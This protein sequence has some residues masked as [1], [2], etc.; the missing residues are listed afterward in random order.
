MLVSAPY[1]KVTNGDYRAVPF[2]LKRF[3]FSYVPAPRTFVHLREVKEASHAPRPF[4]GFGDFRG[5]S[6][7]QL[8]AAFP[9]PECEPD[10]S[11]LSEL[12]ALAG[13]RQEITATGQ[14]LGAGAEDIFLAENFTR[15]ALD[16]IDFRLY[17]VVHFATHA[18]L[19]TE[20]RC[21][22]EPTILLSVAANAASA[23]DAFLDSG[24]VLKLQMDADLVILSACNT[25]GPGGGAGESM[26]G[27]ARS[28]FFAGSRGLLVTHWSV[29]D[30]SADFIITR[31]MA[32]AK[33][34]APSVDTVMALRQA[35]LDRLLG[36]TGGNAAS[37]LFSH[38]F[39]WAPFI[40]IGDGVRDRGK[41]T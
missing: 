6:R 32:P 24:D 7:A 17:R 39:A 38:P 14:L 29:D 25:A 22:T 18:F 12:P 36:Q 3:A 8:A 1:E 35:K 15:A 27:L 21:K 30:D 20:I 10:V 11:A 2:L 34:G 41:I 26:S 33:A 13:T 40:L 4:V 5:A 16:K 37:I 19:P 31:T 28:F 9:G 23:K